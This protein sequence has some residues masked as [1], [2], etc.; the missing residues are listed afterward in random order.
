MWEVWEDVGGLGCGMGNAEQ[1]IDIIV[2]WTSSNKREFR[3]IFHPSTL[4]NKLY[5]EKG[6]MER[7]GGW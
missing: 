3:H 5:I 6:K 7:I 2:C 4:I 1:G